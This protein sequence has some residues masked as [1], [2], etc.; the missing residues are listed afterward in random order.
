MSDVQCPMVGGYWA[1]LLVVKRPKKRQ[2]I[3]KR[4]PRVVYLH[5]LGFV[6][7][8][9]RL[10]GLFWKKKFD[11]WNFGNRACGVCQRKDVCFFAPMGKHTTLYGSY[12]TSRGF[13]F[14]PACSIGCQEQG[15]K[16]FKL[17]EE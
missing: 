11:Y 14:P 8:E 17:E 3:N 16:L 4:L 7:Q 6:G 10:W 12:Q 1:P 9:S 13:S 5:I 2:G 15:D